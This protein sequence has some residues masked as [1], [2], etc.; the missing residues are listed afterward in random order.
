MNVVAI[1]AVFLKYILLPLIVILLGVVLGYMKKRTPKI[2]GKVLI[3]YILLSGLCLGIPGVLGFSGNLF[4]PFWYLF[5]MLLYLLLGMLHVNLISSYFNDPDHPQWFIMLFESLITI[6]CMLLG[7]YFFY[8][9]FNW[10]S[11]FEGYAL[12]ATT[13]IIIFIVPLSFYYCYIQYINIPFEIHKTWR[14]TMN[15]AAVD[16]DKIEFR[17][18]LLLN[19]ELTKTV[20]DGQKSRIDAKAPSDGISVGEWF[21]RVVDDYNHK[22]PN[23]PIHLFNLENDPYSWIFYIKKSIFHLRK[24]ID[25]DKTMSENNITEHTTIICRRVINN[26]IADKSTKKE[27]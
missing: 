16:F 17:T 13:S 1:K 24:F 3:V 5:S 8:L 26:E 12:M 6:I 2:K 4:N 9:I 25:F 22:Y 7:G 21:Y 27:Y 23:S 11:P 14:H 15:H 20:A 10:V 19:L 18:L